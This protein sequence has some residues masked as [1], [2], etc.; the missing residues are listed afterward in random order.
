MTPKTNR[1]IAAYRKLVVR[2]FDAD[3][4]ENE[5][6]RHVAGLAPEE[7][8]RYAEATLAIDKAVD[9]ALEAADESCTSRVS[10][11]TWFRRA[12]NHAGTD[13]TVRS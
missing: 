13:R 8:S 12:A 5:V 7:F 3:E 9:E 10:R 1:A 4:L 6:H 2:Q 11:R